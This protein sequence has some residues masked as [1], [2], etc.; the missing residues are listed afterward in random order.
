LWRHGQ[1]AF[2][3]ERRFQGQTD[4]PLNAVGRE[5]AARAARYLAALQPD[6]IFASDLTRAAE[7]AAAL[8]RLTGLSVQLDKDLRERHGGLWEGLTDVEIRERYPEAHAVWV[9]PE[10]ETAATVADRGSAALERIADSMPSGTT[11]VV[12]G[13]G[14]NLGMGLARLLGIPDG[15]RILGA[16]GNCRWSVLGRRGDKWRLQEHNVGSLPEPV[17]EPDA[18]HKD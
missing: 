7:T 3:A 9:P 2:N 4:I 16:F 17:P 18:E 11:A 15:A 1:T 12:T 5:Q 10:G 13:H 6:A 14:A 8:A